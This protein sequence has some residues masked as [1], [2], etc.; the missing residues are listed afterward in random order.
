M[1]AV[2]R[3]EIDSFRVSALAL[4]ERAGQ[5]A[6]DALC[7]AWPDI[8]A[9]QA[10]VLCGPGNNGGDGF[11]VARALQARGIR[12]VVLELDGH[13]S[14]E[15][16]AMRTAWAALGE[17]KDFRTQTLA[18][19]QATIDPVRPLLIVDA[20]FGIGLSRPL[21]ASLTYPWADFIAH[22]RSPL[23]VVAVD[24]PSG[25][26]DTDPDGVRL[27]GFGG[28]AAR[29][30]TLTFHALKD[31][32]RSMI[33]QGERVEV[34]DIGLPHAVLPAPFVAALRK[35]E[36]GHKFNHGH[37]LVLGG[38]V[39][40][41]G[42]ARLAARAALRVGAGLVTLACPPAAL[43]ENSARLDAV[44]LHALRDG[45]ALGL[46]LQDKRITT[47]CLGPGLGHGPR[48]Q[49]MVATA[50]ACGRA[51]VLDADALTLIARTPELRA[52][53]HPACILTPHEGEFARLCPD[54]VGRE[55]AQAVAQAARNLGCVVLLKGADTVISGPDGRVVAAPATGAKAA[56]WL[57][58][59]GSGDVL[60]GLMTG[61]CA[62]GFAALDAA[63][64]AALLH[65]AA[66]RAFGP[67]LI[68]EDLPDLI[69][70]VL[71]DAGV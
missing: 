63:R 46:M 67:G 9:A 34:V 59:A 6:V 70:Q 12:P 8:G 56:P 64:C 14:P 31:A 55:R 27:A 15:A 4:M 33:A 22:V 2:E 23:W 65:Q 18:A 41:G 36:A 24:V 1:R 44:M 16:L 71:R 5:A 51:L 13:R 39:G 61:L 57:A 48:E 37:A 38:G 29:S 52:A 35:S 49:G 30:L 25:V 62:R 7:A 43:I 69:P 26:S 11:V 45:D 47:L 54:L 19:L 58:T 28:D 50:L 68:A 60:A 66:A 40:R 21:A 42:A 20:L 53:L 17:V 10:V 32:H 3:R